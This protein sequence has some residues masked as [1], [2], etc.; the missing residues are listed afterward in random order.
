MMVI[1]LLHCRALTTESVPKTPESG[2]TIACHFLLENSSVF[3]SGVDSREMI[4]RLGEKE[5]G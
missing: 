4:G 5:V 2:L 1:D 3:D